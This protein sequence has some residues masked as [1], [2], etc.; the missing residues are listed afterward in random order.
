MATKFEVNAVIK[1]ADEETGHASEFK[2][3]KRSATGVTLEDKYGSKTYGSIRIT[4]RPPGE[5]LCV[6][7]F[8][9]L[10]I[11]YDV[12]GK[13]ELKKVG[14]PTIPP[15]RDENLGTVKRMIQDGYTVDRIATEFNTSHATVRAYLKKHNLETVGKH[16]K[17]TEADIPAVKRMIADGCTTVEIGSW[18]KAS[19]QTARLFIIKHGLLK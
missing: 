12:S 8:N 9:A 1:L 19:Y 15:L 5:C 7:G 11:E 2:I 18:F 3:I 13:S 10:F 6:T 16:I 4:E 17:M 14:R